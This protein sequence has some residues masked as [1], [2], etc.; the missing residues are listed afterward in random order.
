MSKRCSWLVFVFCL[1]VLL[2]SWASTAR[3]ASYTVL[4]L[5]TL[6]GAQSDARDIN[7]AGQVAGNSYLAGDAVA[8]GYRTSPNS[9]INPFTD[10]VGTLSL[11]TAITQVSAINS[12]GQVVGNST[13]N[14]ING[15]QHAFRTAP[16]S[17]INPLTDDLGTFGGDDSFAYGVSNDGR[18]VGW[19][20]RAD[21]GDQHAFQTAPNSPINASADD[22][23]IGTA[24]AL[25]SL[26]QI[27]GAGRFSGINGRHAFRTAPNSP[28]NDPADDLGH[29][30][31]VS[32]YAYDSV[33]QS[34]NDAGQAVGFAT[35]PGDGH[36]R[37]FR[38]APNAKINPATDDLGVLAGCNNSIANDINAAGIVVGESSFFDY[39]GGTGTGKDHAFIYSGNVL[40]D[41][42]DLIPANS[43]WTLRR[44]TAINDFDQIV[45]TGIN[46]AGE[47]HGFL[48]TPIPEP[49]SPMLL[50][51]AMMLLTR[52]R[53]R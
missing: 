53:R 23:G 31:T 13:F 17:K 18:V 11:P 42:N 1:S 3:A 36:V 8:H 41:L 33:A 39:N 5:G 37:A 38:T 25:N 49:A 29:L 30:I 16:N 26:G 52:T 50:G 7:N 47:M 4:D 6:G 19:A 46:S 27:V 32:A 28:I 9:P 51:A 24:Y 2:W 21:N 40:Q 44:A 15:A 48:L 10:D 34:T 14:P 12:I 45:G 22:R 43:G 20:Y 35:F